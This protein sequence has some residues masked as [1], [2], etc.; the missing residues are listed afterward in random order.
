MPVT[1]T[2]EQRTVLYEEAIVD[3]ADTTDLYH[4]LERGRYDEAR[5]LRWEYDAVY[6]LIDDLGWNPSDPGEQFA[7]TMSGSQLAQVL[8]RVMRLASERL[9][10]YVERRPG[11][12]PGEDP[13]GMARHC[14]AVTALCDRLLSELASSCGPGA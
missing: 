7:I 5:R 3:L 9:A 2:R 6:R 14:S 11:L 1:T 8:R 4:A 10:A 12:D 13:L